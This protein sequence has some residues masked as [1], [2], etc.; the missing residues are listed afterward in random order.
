MARIRIEKLDRPHEEDLSAVQA[1]QVVGAGYYLGPYGGNFGPAGAFNFGYAYPSFYN[2]ASPLTG[3]LSPM[4]Y[5]APVV[6]SVISYP[7]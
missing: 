2:N 6:P 7:W 1:G 5:S 4:G 3:V